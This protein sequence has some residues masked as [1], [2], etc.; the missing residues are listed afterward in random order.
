[1]LYG[2]SCMSDNYSTY[3]IKFKLA[4]GIKVWLVLLVILLHL[5]SLFCQELWWI[6]VSL[7]GKSW[8]SC[9]S[10]LR[11]SSEHVILTVSSEHLTRF[12]IYCNEIQAEK[13][14]RC[15]YVADLQWTFRFVVASVFVDKTYGKDVSQF[16]SFMKMISWCTVKGC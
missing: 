6:C 11:I 4:S 10:S 14:V 9:D 2:F 5:Q 13:C 7:F 12:H 3:Y 1:M 15:V 8:I 16:S